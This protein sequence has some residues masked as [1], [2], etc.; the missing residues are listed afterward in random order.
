MEVI[1]SAGQRLFIDVRANVVF[2]DIKS[3]F[4]KNILTA[5]FEVRNE[6]SAF[7]KACRLVLY[8]NRKW[9]GPEKPN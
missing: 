3:F 6:P 7:F 8:H 9:I 1:C 5:E 2:R 4:G